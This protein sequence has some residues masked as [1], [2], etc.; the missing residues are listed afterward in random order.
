M[1]YHF[2]LEK[3]MYYYITSASR[4]LPLKQIVCICLN[5]LKL[6]T[7]CFVRTARKIALYDVN[8]HLYICSSGD[9][10]IV[11]LPLDAPNLILKPD[12]NCSGEI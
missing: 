5:E 2:C 9:S 3:D 11:Q 4:L 7:S 10:G 8:I 6:V 1:F 12:G